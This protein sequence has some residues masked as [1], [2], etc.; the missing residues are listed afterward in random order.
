MAM[1]T[2]RPISGQ[3][4]FDV[5]GVLL[6]L[7]AGILQRSGRIWV[8]HGA[9]LGLALLAGFFLSVM[10]I[11]WLRPVHA[12]DM[13]AYLGAAWEDRYPMPGD[14]HHAVWEA[15]RLGTSPE[16]FAVLAE[17]D[18]YRVRQFT[19]PLAFQSQLGMY[20]IKWL[21][22]QLVAWLVPVTGAM[23][24]GYVINLAAAAGLFAVLAWWLAAVRML[25]LA[26]LV[27]ALLMVARFPSLATAE[28]PDLLN[29]TLVC[30]ALLLLDRRH[31]VAG[32]LAAVLAVAVRPDSIVLV[33]GLTG[34]FWLWR[35]AGAGAMALA[36]LASL[37]AYL[38][39]QHVS[40]HPGWWPH[41]WFSTY[42]IQ[43]DMQGFQP[44]FS[45]AVYGIAFAWNLV[46]SAFEDSWLGLYLGGLAMWALLTS[47]GLGFSR[48]RTA[49]IGA[50]LGAIALKFIIFP[51]HDGRTYFPMLVPALLL[52]LAETRDRARDL[53][54]QR[55]AG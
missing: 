55:R 23:H 54:A 1:E 38:G 33:A 39:I 45:M 53:I 49:L 35:Q 11:G 16:R 25:N 14:L 29:V 8:C 4:G 10:V 32:A 31:A 19:D 6:D 46:R 51:L 30:A 7:I 47:G 44:G 50:A 26:P 9:A 52:M 2:E 48:M 43:E 5:R 40:H 41:L 13:I 28:T 12:W 27:V 17:G 18:A 15:V 22:V 21:Y 42:Q 34:A 37:A 36:L 24:A 20:E 3:G